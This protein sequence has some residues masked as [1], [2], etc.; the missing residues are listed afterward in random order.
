MGVKLMYDSPPDC[1]HK[2]NIYPKECWPALGSKRSFGDFMSTNSNSKSLAS[3]PTTISIDEENQN[4]ISNELKSLKA[5][6]AQL[7][8]QLSK[9]QKQ[10]AI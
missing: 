4:S 10:S 2:P 3:L 9:S 1:F 8:E 7:I 5:A 6:N